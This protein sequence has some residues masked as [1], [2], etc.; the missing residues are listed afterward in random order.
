MAMDKKE[1]H[2]FSANI[3]HKIIHKYLVGSSWVSYIHIF[4]VVYPK[5]CFGFNRILQI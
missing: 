4:N 2:V 5:K 3:L 1:N